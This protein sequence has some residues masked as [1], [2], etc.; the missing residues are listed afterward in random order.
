VT[1]L[2]ITQAF[3]RDPLGFLDRAYPAAGDIVRTGESEWSLGDPM[4]ARAVLVNAAGLYEDD[5]E[6][7]T[8]RH[9]LLE[10]REARLS[11]RREARRFLKGYLGSRDANVSAFL[12]AHLQAVSVWPDAGNRLIYQYLKSAFLAQGSPP[13][14]FKLVDELIERTVL[15]GAKARLVGWRRAIFQFRVTWVLCSEID[16]RR[17]QP[18]TAARDLLDVIV[19]AADRSQGSDELADVYLAFL[20][21]AAGSIG[22]LLGWVL[23]LAGRHPD[24]VQGPSHDVV[25]EALRLWPVAWMLGRNATKPHSISDTEVGPGQTVVACPYLIHRNPS[26]WSEPKEFRPARWAEGA[27]TKNPAF[28]PFGYGPQR[29][30]AADLSVDLV[31]LMFETLRSHYAFG[32]EPTGAVPFAGPVLASPSFRLTVSAR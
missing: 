32:V 30:I 16:R 5:S 19:N 22:F 9:G 4:A 7:F 24:R 13:R 8:T 27:N 21:S 29:C 10:P 11:V 15:A 18:Q 20:F 25:F 2:S 23:Y 1:D 14:V 31:S 17:S 6:F 28:M 26:Y 3:L 12:S